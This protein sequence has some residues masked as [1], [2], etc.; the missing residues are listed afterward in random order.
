MN[1][2]EWNTID[3]THYGK[4]KLSSMLWSGE[5]VLRDAV[6]CSGH[7]G[8]IAVL[9]NKDKFDVYKKEDNLKIYTNIGRLIS[10]CKLNSD[11]L[12]CFG[13]NK[14]NDLVFL[15]KD[16]IVRVYSC[17]CE[18]NFV[19][20]LDESIKNEGILY[21]SICEE[22]IIIIT[23]RLNVFVNYYFNGNNC[24]RYPTVDL[25]GKP[26]CVCSVEEDHLNEE[27]NIEH[28]YFDSKPNNDLLRLN[29]KN[30]ITNPFDSKKD[31]E[32]EGVKAKN[33]ALT[34]CSDN[35]NDDYGY[36]DNHAGSSKR[37][38][39]EKKAKRTIMK[40]SAYDLNKKEDKNRISKNNAT[41]K[42]KEEKE[43]NIHLLIALCNGGFVL[44]NKH[45]FKFYD[46]DNLSPYVNMCLSKSGTI[47]AFLSD[48]GV[49]KIFLTKN[50]N[51]CIEETVLDGKKSIKQI[52]WCG[53]DC[54]AVY[55][56][57]ITPSN[58]IQHMLFIGG[59]KNQW[60]PYQY[61]SDLFLI[62]D[63]YGVKIISKE[64]CEY[65]SRIRK[66]TFNIFSIG[67]CT[68]S[69]M[70]FYS[71][72]KYKNGNISLDDEIRAFNNNLHVA[73]DEC[74]NAATHEY[75]ESVINLLLQTSLFGK[76]FMKSNYDC[77]KFLL[78]CLYLRIC[79]N[80]RR[81]PLDIFLTASELQHISIPSFVNY[82]AK[83]KEY[84]L[85]YRI[86]EYAGIKT[87]RILIE[88]CKE[89]IEK[90]IELT[91][92][93]LCAAIT[94]KIGNKKNMDYSYIAFVAAKCLR[95]QLA[96]IIIQYEE[97]KKKQIDMLLKLANYGVAME[98]AILSKDIELVYMCIVNILNQEKVNANGERELCTL[99]DVFNKNPQAA[100]CFYTYCT[101]T[102][103]YNLLKEY[104][105][106]SGQHSKAA[107]VTLDLALSK[108]NL[109]Q[110]KTW[111]AYAAGFL[112]TDQ[113]NSHMKFVHKS[114]M[115][116]IDLLNYQKELE[117]KYN[118]KSVIGYPHKIQGLS[119]MSTVEYT[120]SV[121]EFLD[122]D[123]IFKK[124]K[125]SEPK[126]WRCKIHAL[127][128]NKYFDELYNF[129]N[130]RVS[131]IG[132]DYF[133][134]CAHEYGSVPLTIKLIQKIKDLNLQHKWFTKLNMQNEA[135]SVLEEIKAQKMTTSSLLQTISDA[136][137]NIR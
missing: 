107:F 48:S 5:D 1:T 120:L 78:T 3:N 92:E 121:G 110:K 19:F 12:I 72:E 4:Q 90:S 58:Y 51:N 116:N 135:D 82:I 125:I 79:M 66:S 8:L 47:L 130:Y 114:L 62:G 71:Y 84:L 41:S 126:F 103:Q 76:N 108:K 134:E 97:N 111:L 14:N 61:R 133:I 32:S 52:V 67:S 20:S 94:D 113:M 117:I 104:Y 54:L 13:W 83:R 98:K 60:I 27:L 122:A 101:K 55:T 59:P 11:G 28:N 17:F 106:K 40:I 33:N 118:K 44:M 74:L 96:T 45:R 38:G 65:I 42:K 85:A 46:T 69:A 35:Y 16:N 102:K 87:D 2:N 81:P 64:N 89:K 53:D 25:K 49:I 137:S 24:V 10:S 31:N 23:E 29:I 21:G 9:R 80:V 39:G 63:I 18:K 86:C 43:L 128:K 105:E 100:N 123:H 99:I 22:G 136:I 112:T 30:Y 127:A 6:A 88:W 95:P 91:D 115:N 132:M 73:I 56:P 36:S 50:L 93:Q 131:P 7:L 119:L 75:S 129:A 26:N 15:F 57:M 124:F 68:P 77:K 109:D 37:G 34:E 70:L